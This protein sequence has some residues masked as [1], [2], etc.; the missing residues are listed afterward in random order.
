MIHGCHENSVMVVTETVINVKGAW[1]QVTELTL[2]L[3]IIGIVIHS[4][5]T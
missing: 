5:Y 1:S 2:T 3:Y 4:L